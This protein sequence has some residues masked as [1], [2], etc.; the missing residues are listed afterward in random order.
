MQR[1]Y[2][3]LYKN[4][5]WLW[6]CLFFY[7]CK[8]LAYTLPFSTI[9]FPTNSSSFYVSDKR[10]LPSPR[11]FPWYLCRFGLNAI[12]LFYIGVK[13]LSS[14][15]APYPKRTFQ[16]HGALLLQESLT[17]TNKERLH[18]QDF[19]QELLCYFSDSV[20]LNSFVIHSVLWR[21]EILAISFS[22]TDLNEWKKGSWALGG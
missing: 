17:D 9:A 13:V 19:R 12:S 5:P 20:L 6:W 11:S 15:S 8:G 1:D 10:R 2:Q 18:W 14:I 7:L 16:E 21:F 4:P 22:I 3:L